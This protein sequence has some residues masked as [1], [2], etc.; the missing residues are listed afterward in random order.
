MAKT[1]SNSMGI[2]KTSKKINFIEFSDV[3]LGHHRT[4]TPKIIDALYRMLPDNEATRNLDLI[5]IAG[6]LFD[7]LLQKNDEHMWL[8]EIWAMWLIQ[9]CAKYNIVLRILEGTPSHDWKQ[10]LMFKTYNEGAQWQADVKYVT[11]L[12]Y[13]YHAG[14][15]LGI[16]YLPDEWHPDTTHCFK[17]AKRALAENGVGQADIIIMHGAFEY[18]LPAHCGIETHDSQ[19]WQSLVKHFIFC[20]HIHQRSQYGKILVAGS[21]DRLCHGDEAPKGYIA[22][23]IAKDGNHSVRFVDNEK[24]QAYVTIDC[25][26]LTVYEALTKIEAAVKLPDGSF[27]RIEA[28]SGDNVASAIPILKEQYPQFYWDNPKIHSTEV[29]NAS[30]AVLAI[31][32]Y[33][34]IDLTRDNLPTLLKERLVKRGLTEAQVTRALA[35]LKESM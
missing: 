14:L 35:L 27:I 3:H 24:A 9:K 30:T 18:Q 31:D 21:L 16:L 19:A 29:L 6:D 10:S 34:P 33:I 12:E 22:G 25:R 7:R 8:I 13:E 2:T 11:D 4:K 23:T 15:D 26:D 32:R 17:E 1:Q 20:G 28:N 5:I